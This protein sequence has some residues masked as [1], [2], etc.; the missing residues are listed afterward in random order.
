MACAHVSRIRCPLNKLVDRIE[1]NK[2]TV[3]M[4]IFCQIEK[5]MFST[6]ICDLEILRPNLISKHCYIH[7]LFN[8][9]YCYRPAHPFVRYITPMQIFILLCW[10]NSPPPPPNPPNRLLDTPSQCRYLYCYAGLTLPPPPPT[11]C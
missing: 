3:S 6:R 7:T 1:H 4:Y 2:Q 9:N 11:V 5:K 8:P 10:L